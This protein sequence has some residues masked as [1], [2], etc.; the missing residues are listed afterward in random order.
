VSRRRRL[1]LEKPA[2][3]GVAPRGTK[4]RRLA[5][6]RRETCETVM[7]EAPWP[8]LVTTAGQPWARS[9]AALRAG[10]L[11][12]DIF[13]FLYSSRDAQLRSTRMG[14]RQRF[15]NPECLSKTAR[16]AGAVARADGQL[17][18]TAASVSAAFAK[19][20]A[21]SRS[22]TLA[23]IWDVR[24]PWRHESGLAK[25]ATSRAPSSGFRR[26]R[27]SIARRTDPYTSHTLRLRFGPR[28]WRM[29]V[30]VEMTTAAA[31]AG[32]IKSSNSPDRAAR[33]A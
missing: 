29:S 30:R 26:V 10:Y 24:S 14:R 19:Q 21:A 7:P 13:R 28:D 4:V 32:C 25:R 5:S 31:V 1:V 8:G 9:N 11:A 23:G 12:G 16:P 18:R 22:L 3:F 33:R 6:T 20:T 17:R 27:F 2:D 15:G